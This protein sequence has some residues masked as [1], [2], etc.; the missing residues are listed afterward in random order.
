[1]FR[2]LILGSF[3]LLAVGCSNATGPATAAPGAVTLD[4]EDFSKF[5]LRT[6]GDVGRLFGAPPSAT[7]TTFD[8]GGLKRAVHARGPIKARLS[9]SLTGAK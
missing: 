1:M 5:Q 8:E 9:A 4:A 7:P 2:T 6:G 3:A